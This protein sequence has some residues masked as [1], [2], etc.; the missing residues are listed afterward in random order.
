[1]ARKTASEGRSDKLVKLDGLRAQIEKIEGNATKRFGRLAIR[2]GLAEL[3]LSD[4]DLLRELLAIAA[5]F[6]NASEIAASEDAHAPLP[7]GQN[8]KEA[9][10]GR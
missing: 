6:R 1:M 2:A 5:R 3:T 9:R 10:H 7:G 4:G 8:E